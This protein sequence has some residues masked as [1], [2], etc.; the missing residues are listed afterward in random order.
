MSERR[1]IEEVYARRRARPELTQ[2]YS[3]LSPAELFMVHQ[4][5][6]EL[7]RQFR[8]RGVTPEWLEQC[9]VLEVG[10]GTGSN[11]R[12]VIDFGIP[13]ANL[14]GFDLLPEGLHE[15]RHRC[16]QIAL[17]QA[18]G[19]AIPFR[20]AAFDL[21]LHF[22][23]FSSLPR[24]ETRRAFA[25]EMRRVLRPNGLI[26]WFDFNVNNPWNAEVKAVTP[27]ELRTLFPIATARSRAPSWLPR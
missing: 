6:R 27:A 9:R 5:E 22:T 12:R 26:L 21:I 2:R 23:V 19:R 20:D 13:A 24:P 7:V 3:L 4:R 10:S 17:V 16:P 1:Q 11:L 8:R 18:D 15:A 14:F 25:A